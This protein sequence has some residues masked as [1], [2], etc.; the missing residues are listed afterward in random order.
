[1]RVR[2]VDVGEEENIVERVQDLNDWGV[3][4]RAK[5]SRERGL[6]CERE[7]RKIVRKGFVNL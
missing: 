3:Q 4:E 7:S 6:K 5:S 1:M 2:Q